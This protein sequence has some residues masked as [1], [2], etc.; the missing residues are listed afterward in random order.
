M[1]PKEFDL[2]LHT[3]SP[4]ASK[5]RKLLGFKIQKNLSNLERLKIYNSFRPKS[6]KPG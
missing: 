6:L 3:L 2:L 4:R 5:T 1:K